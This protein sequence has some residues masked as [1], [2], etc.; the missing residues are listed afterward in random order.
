MT[1]RQLNI[2]ARPKVPVGK[3]S[4]E[5]GSWQWEWMVRKVCVTKEHLSR[6]L[7]EARCEL[8]RT[9]AVLRWELAQQIGERLKDPVWMSRLTQE[10]DGR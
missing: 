6:A 5:E 8:D 10:E 3:E 1:G 2:S 7:T 9:F 4:Q